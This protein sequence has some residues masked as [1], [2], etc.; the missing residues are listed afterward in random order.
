MKR[1]RW[2]GDEL[3]K[4]IRWQ[5]TQEREVQDI[6][7]LILRSYFPDVVDEDAL[8]KLGHSTYKADFGIRSLKLIIEA[9]FATTKDDFKKIEKEVQEDCIP[10]LRDL[11]YESLIVF[12]YDDSA[13]VQEHDTTRRALMEIPGIVDVVIVSRPS[14]LPPKPSV[15]QRKKAARKGPPE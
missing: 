10:Y 15:L 4:P 1:W 5:V 3:Q 7:W 14:Q 12:I 8:P 13:S 11:R 6:L 2:D 9:K